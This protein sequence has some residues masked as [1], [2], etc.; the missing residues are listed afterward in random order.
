[1]IAEGVENT[2]QLAMLLAHGCDNIQGYYFSPPLA[3]DKFSDF[4]ATFY[5]SKKL[6][7]N[8]N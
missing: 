3:A 1:M 2:T 8:S 6:N 4:V 5:S 7:Q